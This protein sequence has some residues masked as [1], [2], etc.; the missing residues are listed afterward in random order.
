VKRS[1]LV[2]THANSC[3]FRTSVADGGRKALVQITE[4]CNLHC[5]HCFV[6]SGDWGEHMRLT[7]IVERVLPRLLAARV[8]RVTLTGGEPF[9][10]PDL[11]A[12]CQAVADV[13][14][15]LGV[16]T[17][18]TQITPEQ[19]AHL[20]ELGNVHIN[21]SFD[22]FRPESH[23]RF[24]GN[25][26]SFQV[27]LATTQRLAAA[28]LLQG[29][30]ST[31]NALTDPDEFTYLCAFAAD[32]GAEYVLMNPLSSFG[33]GAKSQRRLA[34][35][36]QKMRAIAAVTERFAGRVDVVRIRF[37]NDELPLGGCEAGRIVYVFADGQVAVCPYLVFAAR[38]PAS[39]YADSEF[40]V[41]NI[42]DDPTP[43]QP[44]IAEALDG[45]D[46]HARHR[47][48]ANSTCGGCEANTVCGKGCPAAVISRGLRI[49]DV[50]SEQ[51]PVSAG[52]RPLLPISPAG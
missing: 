9:V 13:G 47:V 33:R 28:G 45:Y 52:N 44:G 32:V 3:F 29:L 46:F 36:E 7:D 2:D 16:C 12:I 51:C 31:P 19:I 40:L 1:L 21:V 42:L 10:H 14:L 37:S 17:N 11:L 6:S 18:A 43:G 39:R 23:G 34:A 41:G 15:P 8:E 49:G 48:G 26:A 4:R 25:R 20:R 24:R 30:L 50:D 27:T 35:D 38:T 22:G 5:A